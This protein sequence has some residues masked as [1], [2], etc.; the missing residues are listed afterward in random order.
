[1]QFPEYKTKK[2]KK[3]NNIKH[4]KTQKFNRKNCDNNTAR[5]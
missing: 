5:E 1:M 2:K 3:N 4:Y